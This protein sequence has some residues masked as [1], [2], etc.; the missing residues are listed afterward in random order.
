MIS[1]INLF[2]DATVSY[3]SNL[4]FALVIGAILVLGVILALARKGENLRRFMP[5]LASLVGIFGTFWGIFIG[6][7]GF[8]TARISESIPFLLE[9]MKTAF[10]TS[11]LGMLAS[12]ILKVFYAAADDK[13]KASDDPLEV[14]EK[15]S[16]RLGEETKNSAAIAAL[17]G[18]ICASVA[19][20]KGQ[21]L[22]EQL[23]LLNE[24]AEK[25]ADN[26]TLARR[27]LIRLN[28]SVTEARG[29]MRK[30]FG[31]FA[32]KIFGV[33]SK[34]IVEELKG[35]VE[36]FNVMLSD[37]VGETFR[38]LKV[39]AENL[40]AW[41]AAHKEDLHRQHTDL[42][43][44]LEKMTEAAAVFSGAAGQVYEA[45]AELAKIAVAL[46]KT[47]Y[48]G[49]AIAR[50]SATLASQNE[51]LAASIAA[52]REAGAEAAK[53][54]PELTKKTEHILEEMR[55]LDAEA[56]R[57]VTDAAKTL[58]ANVDALAQASR[59]HAKS[60]ESALEASLKSFGAAM[61]T[62]SEKFANDYA[63][64]TEKLRRI[65]TIAETLDEP[66][67]KRK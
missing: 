15:I 7:S 41:Q 33:A 62:L 17:S 8:D 31:E 49:E 59:D 20:D 24:K 1:Q 10:V 4:F 48:H 38:D 28:E 39:S 30:E 18:S 54:V 14:L 58:E 25:M 46:E 55:K 19:P 42:G 37:L 11:I 2:F 35:V 23:P 34:A 13:R 63:P 21:P 65:L 53:V 32:E 9:G 16:A 29:E 52:I 40:N 57:F 36:R 61:F 45:G 66:A 47:S 22:Y 27:E 3:P 12:I 67:P 50:Q 6:L 43:T 56:A 26:L 44:T 51:T 60:L 5:T 64:L